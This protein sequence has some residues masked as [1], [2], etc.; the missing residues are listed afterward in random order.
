MTVMRTVVARKY[1]MDMQCRFFM[2][3][4]SS[5]HLDEVALISHKSGKLSKLFQLPWTFVLFEQ[6]DS[7]MLSTDRPEHSQKN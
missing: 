5:C 1:A 7:K 3:S 6:S 4:M 2:K